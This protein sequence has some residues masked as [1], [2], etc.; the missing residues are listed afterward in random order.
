MASLFG[1]LGRHARQ[2]GVQGIEEVFEFGVKRLS[3][4]F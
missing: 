3:F 1:L 4:F 2:T